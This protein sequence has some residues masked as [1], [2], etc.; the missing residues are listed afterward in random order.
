MRID[1]VYSPNDVTLD[2]IEQG[3]P[4]LVRQSAPGVY[5]VVGGP[6]PPPDPVWHGRQAELYHDAATRQ[7]DPKEAERMQVLAELHQE[8]TR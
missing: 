5:V 2:L 1:T 4:R 3:L 7:A 8:K 6:K